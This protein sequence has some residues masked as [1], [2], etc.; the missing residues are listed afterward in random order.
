MCDVKKVSY[1]YLPMRELKTEKRY[2][3]GSWVNR[4]RV[5]LWLDFTIA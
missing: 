5:L 3:P 4:T 2:P 1:I